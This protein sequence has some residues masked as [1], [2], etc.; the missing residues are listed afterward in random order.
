MQLPATVTAQQITDAVTAL[1]ITDMTGFES[2][3]ITP[4]M[5]LVS[6]DGPEPRITV[7]SEIPVS[8]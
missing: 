7:T 3:V 1:G 5:L 2:L 8:G 4:Q 6:Q